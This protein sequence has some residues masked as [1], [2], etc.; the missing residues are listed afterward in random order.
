MPRPTRHEQV[1]LPVDLACDVSIVHL[2][3]VA[4]ARRALPA[5]EVVEG[6]TRTFAA[7]ADPTRLRIVA[8]LSHRELCVCD[9]AATIGLTESAVSHQL[10]QLRGLGLV[11]ARR[12]GRMAYYALD[13]DHVATL[14]ADAL[15]HV[16]HAVWEAQQ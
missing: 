14:Y 15:T 5:N 6:L 12:E 13:D 7:L 2:E 9:L 1:H 3:A 8:A 11:R 4:D 16:E 10:R